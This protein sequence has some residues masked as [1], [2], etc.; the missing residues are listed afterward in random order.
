MNSKKNKAY[1]DFGFGSFFEDFEKEVTSIL[2][3]SE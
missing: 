2:G 3:K 1:E